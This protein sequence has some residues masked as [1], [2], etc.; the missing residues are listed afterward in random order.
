MKP[1]NGHNTPVSPVNPDRNDNAVYR[2]PK[3]SMRPLPVFAADG[4]IERD[5]DG[6][7]IYQWHKRGPNGEWILLAVGPLPR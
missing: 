7:E 3:N 5:A 2:A 4:S 1:N 6:N